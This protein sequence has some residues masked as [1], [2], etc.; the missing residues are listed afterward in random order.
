[1]NLFKT[2]T[3]LSFQCFGG[4]GGGSPPPPPPPPPQ[5]AKAPEAAAVRKGVS[6]TASQQGVPTGVGP[7]ALGAPV[8][9]DK[10][11]KKYL[12]GS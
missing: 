1:M 11:G 8:T 10:L 5:L 9:D 7:N 4:G 12:L 2:I 6:E 3:P